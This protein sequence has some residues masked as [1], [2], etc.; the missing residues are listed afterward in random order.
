MPSREIESMTT[1]C[2][3]AECHIVMRGVVE[4]W[5]PAAGDVDGHCKWGAVLII[6]SRVMVRCFFTQLIMFQRLR[7]LRPYP[8]LFHI[9]SWFSS[10]HRRV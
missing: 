4:L 8:Q 10:D 7:E 3:M 5:H 6:R 9:R 2:G 1:F